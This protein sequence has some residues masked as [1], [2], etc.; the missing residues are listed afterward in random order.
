MRQVLVTL[1]FI[2]MSSHA[3]AELP[4]VLLLGDS[5][6][7]GYAPLVAKKLEG[8]AIV[9][10]PKQNCGDTAMTKRLLDG[11]LAESKPLIVHWNNGLHDLK[12]SKKTAMYQVPLPDYSANL[13][14]I[15]EAIRK[16]TPHVLF[17]A[18]TPIVDDRHAATDAAFNWF[19]KDVRAYNEKAVE[20]LLPLG[21]PIHDLNRIVHD[22]DPAKL[23]SKD[24]AHFTPEGY[25]RLAD[26]VAD[27]IKRKLAILS[28]T[29]LKAPASG[30]DAVAAYRKA[31]AEQDALVPEIYKTLPFPAFDIPADKDAWAKRR[32]DVKAKVV[33]A[34]GDLPPRPATPKAHLVSAERHPGF[35][36]ERLRIFNGI[37]GTMS[38]MMLIPDG[39]TKP[40]PTIFWQ[41]SSSFNHT[42]LL[43]PNTNGGAEPLGITFVKRGWVVFAAD[44]AWYGERAGKGPSGTAEL[45]VNQQA[46]QMKYNLLFGRTLWGMFVRDDLVA[47]DYLCTRPEVDVKHIGT[48]GISM[49]STRSWWLAALD[50]RIA[51]TVGVACLTRYE[52]LIKH[53][54][55]RQHGVY[56]FADG[57]LKHFDTEGVISLIAPK[58]VLFLTGELDA[59]SPADGIRTIEEKA[60]GT[61]RALGI[62]DRFRS[63]RYPDIGHTY[64]PTMRKEMLDWFDRWMK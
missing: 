49:G 9:F 12:R 22:G 51:C 2:A 40:A 15:A 23:L 11:W 48:T 45:T 18:T 61:Y 60:G 62:A 46:S 5:I 50:D 64:T 1:V 47:L 6:R 31:E 39:V 63:I 57:L 16:V 28:P 42:Q 59:G 33:A 30:P 26:A 44:A 13:K 7:E 41:H 14:I 27:S 3:S 37:D 19:D 55:L 29:V 43:T 53:G 32:P 8:V 24:G 35:R 21:I 34:L 20:T 52:N 25:E 58:P 10:S 38:A 4:T 56:Y 17:A 36:L 54:Q